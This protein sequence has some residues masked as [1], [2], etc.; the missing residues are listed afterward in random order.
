MPTPAT[1]RQFS[2][3][4]LSESWHPPHG[5]YR[6][7]SARDSCILTVDTAVVDLVEYALKVL[8]SNCLVAT[9]DCISGGDVKAIESIVTFQLLKYGSNF[10]RSLHMRSSLQMWR[11]LELVDP[12]ATSA[13]MTP[14]F[15]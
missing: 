8:S 5:T 13:S 12:L 9:L 4:H 11:L 15:G 1:W 6:A 7:L 14:Q 3:D 2:S 10:G